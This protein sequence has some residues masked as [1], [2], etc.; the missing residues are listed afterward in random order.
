MSVFGGCDRV[1]Q[2]VEQGSLNPRVTGST[3]VSVM[4][5]S[6][7]VELVCDGWFV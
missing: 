2:V 1:A 4:D 5:S 7:C 3:P 6:S